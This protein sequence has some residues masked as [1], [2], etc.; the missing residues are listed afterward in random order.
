MKFSDREI[1][2][3]Q[4]LA[5]GKKLYEIAEKLGISKITLDKEIFYLKSDL[6]A[7][8]IPNL[9]YKATIDGHIEGKNE[10]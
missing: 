4:L 3:L 8:N 2:I 5:E 6:K 1:K 10:Q 9:V 7:K